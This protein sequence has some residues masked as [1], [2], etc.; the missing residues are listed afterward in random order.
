MDDT[1]AAILNKSGTTLRP[2]QPPAIPMGSA[3]DAASSPGKRVP[4]SRSVLAVGGATSVLGSP[5][6][7]SLASNASRSAAQLGPQPSPEDFPLPRMDDFGPGFRSRSNWR[8]KQAAA[9]EY[10][11]QARRWYQK[12]NSK[13]P[14]D[15]TLQQ[16]RDLKRWFD[17]IDGD[18]SGEISIAELSDPLLSTGAA[19]GRVSCSLSQRLIVCRG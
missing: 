4:R 18:G 9:A 17:F 10:D 1:L 7:K 19:H 13:P 3:R 12:H 6:G 8:A 5:G 15:F 16:R 2:Q 11:Q 14:F